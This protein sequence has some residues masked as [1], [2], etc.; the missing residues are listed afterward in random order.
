MFYFIVWYYCKVKSIFLANT[1]FYQTTLGRAKT[2]K[3]TTQIEL[4]P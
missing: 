2:C 4:V 3:K 1:L